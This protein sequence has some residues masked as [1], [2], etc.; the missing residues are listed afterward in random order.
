VLRELFK[1]PKHLATVGVLTYL[2]G[3][4]IESIHYGSLGAAAFDLGRARYILT[5]LL[6][7][8][9][10]IA[11]IYPFVASVRVVQALK[12]DHWQRALIKTFPLVWLLTSLIWFAFVSALSTMSRQRPLTVAALD[13]VT[14]TLPSAFDFAGDMLRAFFIS[15]G[16]TVALVA[17]VTVIF[18]AS[19][20]T[21]LLRRRELVTDRWQKRKTLL[22]ELA[23]AFKFI[24]VLSIF[25]VLTASSGKAFRAMFPGQS[26][27]LG[28]F[29]I[30]SRWTRFLWA[31]ILIAFA[32]Y[33]WM[34]TTNAVAW[35][36][37]ANDNP[38]ETEASKGWTATLV[39]LFRQ[40]RST[41][42]VGWLFNIAAAA[43]VVPYSMFVFPDVP[44]HL[45]GGAPVVARVTFKQPPQTSGVGQI[46]T[47]RFLERGAG[48]LLAT[49]DTPP[50]ILEFPAAA[51]DSIEFIGDAPASTNADA[52]VSG[53]SDGGGRR[54][55]KL[56]LS[57]GTD[58]G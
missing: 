48:V 27:L 55:D 13:S 50:R 28:G 38:S 23:G 39:G 20:V 7:G 47:F 30:D 11:T 35:S 24:L 56:P 6:F 45:G 21:K 12:T 25:Q 44:Q 2:C 16:F 43:I 33:A 1:D 29:E 15:V 51:I 14:Q 17:L 18:G 32:V 52:G 49:F 3:F 8:L 10:A 22:R 5:G 40:E 58:G 54:V 41:I 57:T 37:T 36:S 19:D 53:A 31:P 4:I 9:F 26:G 46:G 34:V 42:Q